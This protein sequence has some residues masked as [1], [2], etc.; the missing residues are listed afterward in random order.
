MAASVILAFLQEDDAQEV[1]Q[2]GN[3]VLVVNFHALAGALLGLGKIMEIV[4]A[5]GVAQPG[6]GKTHRIQRQQLAG[7]GDQRLPLFLL[8]IQLRQAA[9]GVDILGVG[10]NG[11][12]ERMACLGIVV[13]VELDAAQVKPGDGIPGINLDCLGQQRLGFVPFLLA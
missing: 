1:F 7:D 8:Q 13:L 2:L 3:L 9:V 5:Q 6:I 12:F 4:I 10:G 11:L